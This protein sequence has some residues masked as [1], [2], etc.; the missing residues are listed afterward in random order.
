MPG[1]KW[2][3]SINGGSFPVW[4]R[5]GKELYFIAGNGMMMAV[6]IQPG[7]RFTPGIPKPLFDTTGLGTGDY[8]TYDVS[9]DGRFLMPMSAVQS[10]SV[11]MTVV[12]NWTE[13]LKR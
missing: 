10:E 2:Q 13:T 6:P 9:K 11:P 4:S 5:D 3:V 8:G 1:G 7:D 12:I